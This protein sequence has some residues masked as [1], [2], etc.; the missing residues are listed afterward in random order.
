MTQATVPWPATPAFCPSREAPITIVPAVEVSANPCCEELDWSNCR[1]AQELG[2]KLAISP[3]AHRAARL[4]DY[5]HGAELARAAGVC[6][7][8]ILNTMDHFE[9]RRHLARG[10]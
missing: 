3:D 10:R 1:L 2:V 6:C 7:S 5:R 4:V 9:V 8:T